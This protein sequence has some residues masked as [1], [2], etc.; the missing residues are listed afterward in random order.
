MSLVKLTLLCACHFATIA[1]NNSVIDDDT[2][3]AGGES[4]RRTP[5]GHRCTSPS[6]LRIDPYLRPTTPH[7]DA[8]TP[9]HAG[10]LAQ[11]ALAGRE[12]HE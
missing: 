5:G 9:E 11:H 12:A 3:L 10:Q 1:F 7:L 4:D 6:D 8:H 2:L